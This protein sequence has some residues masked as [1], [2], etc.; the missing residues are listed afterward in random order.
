MRLL[1]RKATVIDC[2]T[3]GVP[4]AKDV[5]IEDKR[6]IEI[7][8]V[9]SKN[10]DD[11]KSIDL[12]GKFLMPGLVNCHVH[13]AWDGITDLRVASEKDGEGL[14]A[15]KSAKHMRE[16]I[17][18][19]ILTIRDLGVHQSGII[20]KKA[21]EKGLAVGPRILSSAAAITM[22]KGHTWWCGVEADGEDGVRQAVRQQLYNGADV[23]KIMAS[24][25]T[26]EPGEVADLPEFTVKELKAAVE[27]AH[28]A[29]KKITAHATGTQAARNVVEAGFDCI[30]HGAPFDEWTIDQMAKKGIKLVTT[31]TPW[32]YQAEF[33]EKFGLNK[34]IVERRKRQIQDHERFDAIARAKK[35]GVEVAVGTD[36]GSPLVYHNNLSYEL[37]TCIRLGVFDN[38]MEALIAATISGANV[39]DLGDEIGTVEE[40]KIADLIVLKGNPLD[41]LDNIH[42]IS[43][44]IQE[45]KIIVDKDGYNDK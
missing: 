8:E 39:C 17:E 1:L 23:I 19:G 28:R 29:N 44:V 20:A 45:G 16:S 15:F 31:F 27:E 12:E 5:L 30:E 37:K 13:L 40:G 25:G 11:V 32:F 41:D 18:A 36:A 24:G 22:T 42:N 21:K 3:N 33:G 38:N 2:T 9:D 34:S 43:L 6:I 14:A 35:A 7:S 10:Y 4:S 26:G